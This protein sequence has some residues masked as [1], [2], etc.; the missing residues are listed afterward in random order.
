MSTPLYM[1]TF[2]YGPQRVCR[3]CWGAGCCQCE[4]KGIQTLVTKS[5]E[6]PND[7]DYGKVHS[8]WGS[9]GGCSVCK[10]GNFTEVPQ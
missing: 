8:F 3:E 6:M 10:T 5:H 2:T 1:A 7:P 9:P 4:H